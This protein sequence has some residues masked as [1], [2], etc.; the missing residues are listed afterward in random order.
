MKLTFARIAFI[1]LGLGAALA[2]ST[3]SFANQS[4]WS[5]EN[6]AGNPWSPISYGQSVFVLPDFLDQSNALFHTQEWESKR[7]SSCWLTLQD[8]GQRQ[9]DNLHEVIYWQYAITHSDCPVAVNQDD[10]TKNL[11]PRTRV[12]SDWT[13]PQIIGDF[14]IREFV[15]HYELVNPKSPP[16]ILRCLAFIKHPQARNVRPGYSIVGYD[17]QAWGYYCV[18]RHPPDTHERKFSYDE[19]QGIL[20]QIRKK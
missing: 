5:D 6:A 3:T 18:P 20:Q 4:S 14:T 17:W 8:L 10:K 11:T 13:A 7:I 12:G 2:L 1:T 19:I 15:D 9:Y 16:S